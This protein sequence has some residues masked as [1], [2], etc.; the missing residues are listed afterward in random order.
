[1]SQRITPPARDQIELLLLSARRDE[2]RTQAALFASHLENLAHF[3]KD[4]S[5]AEIAAILRDQ[6]ELYHRMAGAK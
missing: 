3:I 1:M 4:E 2:R 5:P 6:A